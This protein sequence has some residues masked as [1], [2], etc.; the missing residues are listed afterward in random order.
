MFFVLYNFIN[1][2]FRSQSGRWLIGL[3]LKNRNRRK[4]LFICIC[5]F[6]SNEMANFIRKIQLFS[7]WSITNLLELKNRPVA[8]KLPSILKFWNDVI[9]TAI[10]SNKQYFSSLKAILFATIWFKIWTYNER[11]KYLEMRKWVLEIIKI[12]LHICCNWIGYNLK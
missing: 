11:I 4:W 7:T 1:S 9:F 10:L 6:K 3:L 12:K 8:Q 5:L 2:I